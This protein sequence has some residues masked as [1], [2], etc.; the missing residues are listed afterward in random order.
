MKY[1]RSVSTGTNR[2]NIGIGYRSRIVSHNSENSETSID[3]DSI[4]SFA[5]DHEIFGEPEALLNSIDYSQ[6]GDDE[7]M[8]AINLR[9]RN[10]QVS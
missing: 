2:S 3:R 8:Q 10:N 1:D 5:Y 4:V 6:V 7:L 9:L